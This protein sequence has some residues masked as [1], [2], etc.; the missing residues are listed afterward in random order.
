MYAE[1]SEDQSRVR[2]IPLDQIWAYEMPG[3]RD[4]RELEPDNFGVRIRNLRSAEQAIKKDESLTYQLRN[5]LGRAKFDEQA[6]PGF[7]VLGSGKEA[8][9]HAHAVL[10][11]GQKPRKEFPPGSEISLVFFSKVFDYYV[12]LDNVKQRGTRITTSYFIVPH[13]GDPTAHFALIP[14]GELR[15]GGWQVHFVRSP[16]TKAKSTEA[17]VFPEPDAAWD[18]IVVCRPFRFVVE[19]Q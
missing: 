11:K 4:V 10:V 1:T 19:S 3:T 13:R 18:S 16:L 17:N 2:T 7:A 14:L 15:A 8:L 6:L 9:R 5:L 12:H